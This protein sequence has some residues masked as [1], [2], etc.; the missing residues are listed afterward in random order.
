VLFTRKGKERMSKRKKGLI[1]LSIFFLT[2]CTMPETRIYTLYIPI[3]RETINTKPYA[4]IVIH[5]NSERY[6]K[7]PYI[8]Y[9]NSPYQLEIS[10]YS[11]WESSPDKMI[12]KEFKDAL[13]SISLFKEV[14][15]SNVI[16]KGFYSL[17]INLKRFERFD[18]E[19]GSFAT[20]AFDIDLLS[21]DGTEL[22]RSTISKKVEL[23]DRKFSS[24]AK[25][26]S[27]ALKQGVEEVRINIVRTINKQNI[28]DNR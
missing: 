4:S 27:R 6:L 22:Y 26:L 3:E 2:A 13:S 9:R 8:A 28:I 14:R 7:Q 16:P 15:V 1:F 25:G 12:R 24:L 23:D 5:M 18:V 11:K 21:P 19:K 20:L 10:R 17:K